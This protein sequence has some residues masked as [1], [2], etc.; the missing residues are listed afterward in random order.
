[1]ST[2][3]SLASPYLFLLSLILSLMSMD[4]DGL[5]ESSSWSGSGVVVVVVV[6]DVVVVE[7]TMVKDVGLLDP[8]V[9]ALLRQLN[10]LLAVMVFLKCFLQQNHNQSCASNLR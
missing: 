2:G 6:V 3:E 1:M 9:W 7:V 10:I 4:S 5:N 8:K